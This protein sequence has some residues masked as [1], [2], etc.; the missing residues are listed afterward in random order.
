MAAHNFN[1]KFKPREIT[2]E[3]IARVAS[4]YQGI[5]YNR[6]TT[7]I[8]S[9]PDG[10]YS[11]ITNCFGFKLRVLNDLELYV[12]PIDENLTPSLFGQREVKTLWEII[13]LNFS[14]VATHLM[15][16]GDM[17]LLK[18]QDVDPRNRTEHHIAT[19]VSNMAA[20]ANEPGL[21][22]IHADDAKGEVS[23]VP[24]TRIA[25]RIMSVR[26]MNLVLQTEAIKGVAV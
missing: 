26:R 14:I 24:I 25:N 3:E 12:P 13:N 16:V 10:T 4:R 19:V 18:Y 17:L 21:S 15:Q 20:Y 1:L 11:G 7:Q 8:I 9:K 6:G 2:G 23:T 5:A 22:M